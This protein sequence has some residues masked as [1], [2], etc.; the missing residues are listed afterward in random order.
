MDGNIHITDPHENG[1]LLEDFEGARRLTNS[2][3]D[4]ALGHNHSRSDFIGFNYHARTVMPIT[5]PRRNNSFGVVWWGICSYNSTETQRQ[6]ICQH[7]GGRQHFSEC[8]QRGHGHQCRGMPAPRP[9]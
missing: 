3:F 7:P 1:V 9:G 2:T 4:R 6:Q 5:I 8:D